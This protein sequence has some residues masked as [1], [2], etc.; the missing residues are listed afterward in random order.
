M[1]M[2]NM[3][4]GV[5]RATFFVAPLLFGHPQGNIARFR[6]CFL[7]DRDR[8]EYINHIFIYT[9]LGGG[10]RKDYLDDIARMQAHEC[11][12]EDYDDDFDNTYATFVFKRPDK[13]IKDIDS[14]RKGELHNTSKEYQNIILSTFPSI[15]DQ[16]KY[17][18]EIK[19]T[20]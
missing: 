17:A 7:L 6:N 13:F 3:L 19:Q 1:T 9:R 12:V 14:Y 18:F 11:Y 4:N 2:Y 8:P 15:A 16:I 5:T 10:N 20:S